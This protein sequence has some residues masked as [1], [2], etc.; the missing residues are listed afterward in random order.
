MYLG[1]ELTEAPLAAIARAFDRDHTTVLYAIR[2]VE[3]RL[4]PGSASLHTIHRARA[5]LGIGAAASASASPRPPA[6]PPPVNMQGSGSSA[7]RSPGSPH[8]STT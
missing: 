1:R 6:S 5:I 3:G 8:S 4:E 2:T 7:R